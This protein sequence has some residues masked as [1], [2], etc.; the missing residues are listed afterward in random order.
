MMTHASL[1]QVIG[2]AL[3]DDGFRRVLLRNPREAVVQVGLASDELSAL[4]QIRAHTLE[5]F[6]EQLVNWFSE[7]ERTCKAC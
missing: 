7:T 2:T 1:S 3:V 5:Q 4:T 6:A